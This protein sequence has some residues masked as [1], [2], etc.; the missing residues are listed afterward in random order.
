MKKNG[1]LDNTLIVFLSD[2]GASAEIAPQYG[3]RF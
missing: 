2:N 3:P 1:Q